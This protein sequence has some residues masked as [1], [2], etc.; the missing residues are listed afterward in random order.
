MVCVFSCVFLVVGQGYAQEAIARAHQVAGRETEC[1]TALN[2]ARACLEKV[3]D[4]ESRSLLEA[5]LKELESD[6]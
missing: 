5:D 6:R 1:T 2:K 3:E 4:P